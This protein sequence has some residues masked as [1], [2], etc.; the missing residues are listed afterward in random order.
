[1]EGLGLNNDVIVGGRKLHVQTSYSEATGS[2]VSSVF[3]NGRVIDRREV[4]YRNG[5]AP[6]VLQDR[7][8]EVHNQTISDFETLFYI[9][10]KVRTV[11]HP[12][13][14]LRLGRLFLRKRLTDEAISV[15][16]LTLDMDPDLVEARVL[17]AHALN[18][19]GDYTEAKSLLEAHADS[20]S[21]FA[22]L[23]NVFGETLFF[24]EQSARAAEQ[25]TRA[26]SINPEFAAAHYN[27]A[28]ALLA[29][30]CGENQDASSED[31]LQERAVEHLQ[32]AFKLA[33]ELRTVDVKAAFG[34]L[35]EERPE[36]ALERLIA[37][38]PGPFLGPD[39]DFEDDFYLKFMYGGKGRD[40]EFIAA[41]VGKLKETLKDY[42]NFADL[43]HNLGVAYLIQCRNLFLKALDEFRAALKINPRFERAKKSLKIAENDGKG[44]LILLRAL[45]K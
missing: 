14:A 44:F 40:D 38:R 19:R 23:H 5:T 35:R 6:S 18:L 21:G 42:P 9:A 1:M 11:R 43:H 32:Q 16:R 26:L 12:G 25:F 30:A 28:L 22:D 2:I 10:E 45:L 39:L 37:A 27:L 36:E 15:L 3:D 33:P 34:L 20:S 8:T 31:D 41:Y 13:S 17:L 7:L 4:S 24:L 29:Q